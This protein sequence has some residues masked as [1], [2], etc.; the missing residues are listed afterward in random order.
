MCARFS[1][2][3]LRDT[4]QE[5]VRVAA[6]KVRIET[7]RSNAQQQ[8][9]PIS[10]V[11]QS[12]AL[13]MSMEAAGSDMSPLEADIAQCQH[14][15]SVS[16]SYQFPEC[17][18]VRPSTCLPTDEVH[19]CLSRFDPLAI[20]REQSAARRQ[21]QQPPPQQPPQQPPPSPPSPPPLSPQP[22]PTPRPVPRTPYPYPPCPCHRC[23]CRCRRR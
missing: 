13:K 23:R 10:T 21:Q 19:T 8:E 6:E 22:T 17:V 2:T 4:E 15:Q 12:Y 20:M 5:K 18:D 3:E 7:M 1:A 16:I 14:K 9:L 11:A